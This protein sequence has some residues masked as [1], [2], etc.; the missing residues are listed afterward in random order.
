MSGRAA[1]ESTQLHEDFLHA[2]RLDE[3]I[4]RARLEPI[5][6]VRPTI[7]G[8]QDQNR[9]RAAGCAPSLED[10]DAGHFRE[11]KIEHGGIIGCR[12]AQM[13][14]FFPLRATSTTKCSARNA[15]AIASASAR[16]S[17][18]SRIFTT[19][20]PRRAPLYSMKLNPT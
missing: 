17:S 19:P 16:S 5:D 7:A 14:P 4:V 3:K 13:L 2:E 15:R 8:R 11:T 12:I 6:F 20:Q 10:L 18:K 9:Q 1:D